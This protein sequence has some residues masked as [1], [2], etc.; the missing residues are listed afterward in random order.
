[1]SHDFGDRKELNESLVWLRLLERSRKVD[2]DAFSA[3]IKGCDKLCRVISASR[4]TAERNQL[5]ARVGKNISD[6]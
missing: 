3:N 1:V 4:R 2:V 6:I 5:Q